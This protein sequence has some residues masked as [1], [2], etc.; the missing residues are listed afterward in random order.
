MD[1]LSAMFDLNAIADPQLVL[2]LLLTL[3][4]ILTIFLIR[5]GILQVVFRRMGDIKIRYT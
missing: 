2:N 5:R 4:V 3:L 1:N